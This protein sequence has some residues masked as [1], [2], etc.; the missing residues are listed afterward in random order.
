MSLLRVNDLH[1][2][3]A[4]ADGGLAPAVTGV[5]FSVELGR[6]VAIVGESGAGKSLSAR[7][8]T[9]LLPYGARATGE[10]LLD[11]RNVLT[12]TEAEK[13]ALRGNTVGMVFQDPLAALNPLHRVGDQV[14]E[15]LRVHSRLRERDIRREVLRLFE[16]VRLDMP[17]K[18]MRAMP[19]QL[20]G[21]Q[22]QRVL[23]AMAVINRPRL[24]IAD[25]PTT[26]LDAA[27]Q[28]EM[29]EMLADLR[30]EMGMGVLLISHDLGMV[31]SFAD[32]V[33][34]MR[35]G[36]FVE[37]ASA[38]RIFS[39]PEHEYTKELLNCGA[40]DFMPPPEESD[41]VLRV[42][43]LHVSFPQP[44]TGFLRRSA[45]LVAVDGVSFS[46][47]RGECL[48]IVGESGSGKS[49]VAL[50]LLRL[51]ASQ[52]SILFAGKELQGL[53]HK[54]MVPIRRHIQVVFQDP[55]AS[56]NPRMT[57]G[58]IISEGL[59]VHFPEAAGKFSRMVADV[60]EKVGLP[61]SFAGRFPHELSGGERQR[62]A[63]ARTVALE[64]DLLILDEPTSSLDRSLQFQMIS[65]LRSLQ[66]G[67]RQ[68]ACLFISHDLAMIR[69]FCHRVYVMRQSQC[70]EQGEVRELFSNPATEYLKNLLQAAGQYT[71]ARLPHG[72]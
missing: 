47:R 10:V 49:S 42:K 2:S 69:G 72:A 57:V 32:D 54:E 41:V 11:D 55:Y 35:G 37:S 70:V 19:Y 16:L 61:T 34:V 62:V 26:A 46:I 31:R 59:E 45:P 51:I 68:M 56:L 18:R 50:A 52:G 22:R 1:V 60:L 43:D 15:A 25:E 30:R 8:V 24:L 9:G 12:M 38:E 28:R 44:S 53:S 71:G 13:T 23:L 39:Q 4:T 17:E 36:R 14:A 20:S 5:S 6:C 64:P 40:D 7:A 66:S 27:V 29:L 67:R 63:I 58:A 3:F 65:L 33:H 21:G 48:G